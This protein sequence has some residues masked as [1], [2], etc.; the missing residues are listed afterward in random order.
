MYFTDSEAGVLCDNIRRIL[1]ERGGVTLS[2]VNDVVK[3]ILEQTG[4]D[5]I[6]NIV[7]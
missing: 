6:I 3:E 7:E 5:S 2:G 4:F 1:E